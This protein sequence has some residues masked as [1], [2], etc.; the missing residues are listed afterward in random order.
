MTSG[1]FPGGYGGSYDD[2]FGGYAG[3]GPRQPRRIDITQLLTER[4]RELGNT[5]ARRAGGAGRPDLGSDHL[6]WAM[7][8]DDSIRQLISRA[9]ADVNQL[10]T[11]VEQQPARGEPHSER[12]SLRPAATR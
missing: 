6:L 7:T 4:A 1:Y 10:R 9:G 3:G 8:E 11:L 12:P 2:I 5:A